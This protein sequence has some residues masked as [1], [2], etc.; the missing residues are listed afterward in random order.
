M[1]RRGRDGGGLDAL[2]GALLVAALA[3]GVHLL[4]RAA[5]LTVA[6]PAA[7]LQAARWGV[8]VALVVWHRW[9]TLHRP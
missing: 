6:R 4:T 7:F 8:V 9:R 3:V 5:G 2:A 1:E